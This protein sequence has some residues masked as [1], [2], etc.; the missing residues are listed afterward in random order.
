MDLAA[1]YL[2]ADRRHR[3]RAPR[4]AE[5]RD[6]ASRPA[7]RSEPDQARRAADHRRRARRYF[8]RRPDRG[9][10]SAVRQHS[11]DRQ[12]HWLQPGV[13]HYGV[14]NG[15]RFRSE[16]APRIA[17]FMLSMHAHATRRSPR[18]AATAKRSHRGRMEAKRVRTRAP[19]SRGRSARPKR[20]QNR[21]S[22]WPTRDE[23]APTRR[24]STR[25]AR[26]IWLSA[27][28][29]DRTAKLFWQWPN[30]YWIWIHFLKPGISG[31]FCD[32]PETTAECAIKVLIN[33]EKKYT[34]AGRS[35]EN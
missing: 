4:A 32:T 34:A 15:S 35:M 14:F 10:A 21:S 27:R 20:A 23:D 2:S 33:K 16:I 6:D 1:E 26:L 31:R 5:R 12:A 24:L 29:R 7:G 18:R 9:G 30:S 3:F 8:R 25:R 22:R 11:A 17:D 13:G 19:A 28:V